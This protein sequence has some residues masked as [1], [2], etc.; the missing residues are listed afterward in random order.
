MLAKPKGFPSPDDGGEGTSNGLSVNAVVGAAFAIGV[1]AVGF[2]NAGGRLT[3]N[4]DVEDIRDAREPGRNGEGT[5][6]MCGGATWYVGDDRSGDF[7]G[8]GVFI[9][10]GGT[11]SNWFSTGA[12]ASR[13]DSDD[14]RTV[15]DVLVRER[16]GKRAELGG[17]VT[18]KDSSTSASGGPGGSV[19]E[20]LPRINSSASLSLET[21]LRVAL[22]LL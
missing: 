2:P 3:E 17:W 10:D 12:W 19:G 21:F 5:P 6:G 8:D 11:G 14:G 13:I 18:L 22:F 4:L 7:G 15:G 20:L 16:T 1:P 9:G